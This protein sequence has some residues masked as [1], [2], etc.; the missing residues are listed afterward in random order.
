M[1]MTVARNAACAIVLAVASAELLAQDTPSPKRP[2]IVGVAHAAFY[3]SDM[4]KARE[5]YEGYLGFASPYALSRPTG[6]DLV[7]IKINDRQSVELFPATEVGPTA[8]RLYH[9]ALEVED[10]EAMRVYLASRGV[11]VPTTTPVG[12]IGNSNYF[13]KDPSGNTVEIVQYMPSSWT[14]REKGNFM[15]DTRISRRMM[16][17]GVMIAN[18][19]SAMTFYRDIL[20]F[21]EFWRGTPP[22]N[23]T[24][25]W[26]NM[27]IPDGEDYVE[28]M[29]YDK[30]PPLERVHSLQHICLEVPSVAEAQSILSKRVLP[31]GSPP[32]G[33]VRVGVNGKRQLNAFDPDGTRVELME[34]VT[35]DGQPR[36]S[37]TAP[38]PVGEHRPP[39]E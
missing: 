16:H 18:L 38:V 13:V 29:L 17:V 32:S 9:I 22:G 37:S 12:R 20:G 23:T 3:V 4:A 6:G 26:V 31:S 24:L 33:P 19:D 35:A 2:R 39:Q 14:L 25:S 27:R 15:P 36:A 5:F 21:R 7:F 28:F 11:T 30:Y 8:E 1:R 34:P 10:A